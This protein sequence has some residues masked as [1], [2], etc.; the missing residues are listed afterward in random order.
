MKGQ[1][2][3]Q[4]AG[5][6]IK[7]LRCVVVNMTHGPAHISPLRVVCVPDEGKQTTFRVFLDGV[8]YMQKPCG[9]VAACY[10]K[11]FILS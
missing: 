4:T 11:D 2:E 5:K 8:N 3:Y 7:K 10:D 1:A 9:T 6:E